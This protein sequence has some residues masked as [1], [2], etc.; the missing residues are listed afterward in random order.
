[1]NT[2]QSTELEA[3]AVTRTLGAAVLIR[4]LVRFPYVDTAL[5][6]ARV[7][8]ATIKAETIQDGAKAQ[9]S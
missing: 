3:Q 4:K 5:K 9:A 7:C 2:S 6:R 1:M 8:Q